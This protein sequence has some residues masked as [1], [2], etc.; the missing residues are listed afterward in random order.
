MFGVRSAI[1]SAA[2]SARRSYPSAISNMI[3]FVSGSFTSSASSR[4]VVRM[5]APPV[6]NSLILHIALTIKIASPTKGAIAQG[7]QIPA[8]VI[9]EQRNQSLAPL[10]VVLVEP[11]Q[12]R[13]VEVED[14]RNR[15]GLDKR[16]D[17]FG[18]RV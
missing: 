6:E 7:V 12:E 4:S 14:A 5:Y 1:R 9:D 3:R 2:R 13:A 18:A 15:A 16:D 11:R 17:E 10:A 8:V